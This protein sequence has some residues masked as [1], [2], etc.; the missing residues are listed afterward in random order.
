M[1]RIE[2]V[3][4]DDIEIPAHHH[5]SRTDEVGD[6]MNSIISTGAFNSSLS[7]KRQRNGHLVIICGVRRYRAMC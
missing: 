1:S 5:R 4:L 7:L 6:L 2:I 3:G